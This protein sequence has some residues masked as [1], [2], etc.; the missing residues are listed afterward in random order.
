MPSV[1]EGG[2]RKQRRMNTYK[3]ILNIKLERDLKQKC[4]EYAEAQGIT[5]DEDWLKGK[6]T[7]KTK[8]VDWVFGDEKQPFNRHKCCARVWGDGYGR[9]CNH[10]KVK[11]EYCLKHDDMLLRYGVL[12]FGDYRVDIYPNN[13]Y[14][15]KD[16]IKDKFNDV[17]VEWNWNHSASIALQS[18]LNQQ[19]KKVCYACREGS[20][21]LC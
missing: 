21:L 16:L 15:G 20:G 10:K 11:G 12:R 14:K 18:I 9:Q 2:A 6:I 3:D 7:E 17:D 8:D 13:P 4:K 1:W 5:L 19:Q